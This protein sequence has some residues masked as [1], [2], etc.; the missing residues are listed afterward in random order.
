MVQ[1]F[2]WMEGDQCGEWLNEYCICIMKALRK[3]MNLKNRILSSLTERIIER[4]S[5]FE[6]IHKGESCYL[7]GNGA[8][9]KYFNLKYFND[10]PSIACGALFLHQDFRHINVKYYFEGHPFYYYPYW[11]NPYSKKIQKNPMGSFYR[12]QK[13]YHEDI[14]LFCNLS[15]Y[16]GIHGDNIYYAHHFDKPFEGFANCKLDGSFTTM[17]SSLSGM[18][19]LAIYMGFKDITLV[20]CDYS[21][22]PQ[23]QGH[24]YEYGRFPDTFHEDPQKELLLDAINYADIRVITPS[25]KYRG[26]ILP[27]INYKD[28]TS[29]E[30]VYKEN[31]EI[32]S[33]SDL[34]NLDRFN[35]LY[36]IFSR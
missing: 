32:L 34:L 20:G 21:F 19:G 18:L 15:N 14:L 5:K 10:K 8:S 1:L 22:F 36:K 33:D 29:D 9:I 31:N 4:N 30:S 35:M 6:N 17:F 25:D 12:E 3:Y 26:N 23:S 24:F 13:L 2:Q 16:F 7:F 11:I 27:H 28:F